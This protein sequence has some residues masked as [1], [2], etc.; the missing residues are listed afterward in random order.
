MVACQARGSLRNACSYTYWVVFQKW[1]WTEMNVT[2]GLIFVASHRKEW[3]MTFIAVR[4]PH[5]QSDHIV[6]RVAEAMHTILYEVISGLE[7]R[8]QRI[9]VQ[10]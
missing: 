3:P 4:C 1:R 9:F 8:V 2:L 7:V 5:C 6:K 10:H